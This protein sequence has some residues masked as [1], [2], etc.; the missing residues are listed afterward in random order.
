MKNQVWFQQRQI[1]IVILLLIVFIGNCNQE[2]QAQKNQLKVSQRD[3]IIIKTAKLIK[4]NYVFKDV[5][6]KISKELLKNHRQG[7]Y[8]NIY[9]LDDIIGLLQN[10]IL[11]ISEDKHFEI[12]MIGSNNDQDDDEPN[13][14]SQHGFKKIEILNDNIAYFEFDHLPGSENDLEFAGGVISDHSYCKAIIFD[15]RENIGGSG[16]LVIYLCSYLFKDSLLLF[17]FHNQEGEVI[18]EAKTTPPDSNELTQLSEIPVYVLIG[19]NTLSAGESLAYILKHFNRA[20]I[21]GEVSAGMAHP[22]RTFRIDDLIYLTIPF[23]RFEHP[24]TGT[25]WEGNGV[26]PDIQVKADSALNAALN[27]LRNKK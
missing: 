16:D 1:L 3:S 24:N 4:D 18:F 11:E 13:M 26:I 19:P 7:V 14:L 23:I 8:K 10:T 2:C 6:N 17:T 21:V 20:T 27:D 12:R 5:G 15:V 25:D 22:S 9:S